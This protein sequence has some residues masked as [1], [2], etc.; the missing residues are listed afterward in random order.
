MI[1]IGLPAALLGVASLLFAH[2]IRVDFDHNA[3]FSCY[4]TYSLKWSTDAVSPQP[5]F[6]NEL[7]QRRIAGFI[8]E[9]LAARGLKP[10]PMGQDLRVS[11]RVD[12]TEQPQFTTFT[13]GWGPGWGWNGNWA[14]GGGW[15]SGISTT[16]VQMIYQGVLVVDIVDA[17]RNKLVFQG[18]SAQTISSRPERNTRKLAKAVAEVFENYP[19][20]P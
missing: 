14:F 13:D 16:T 19:P 5:T 15:G 9:A 10:S 3:N 18:T 1:R 12:V 20:R 17:R 8:E 4:K 7:M 6:P 11:Y 2:K